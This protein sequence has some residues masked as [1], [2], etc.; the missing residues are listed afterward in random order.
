[1]APKTLVMK[2]KVA[3]GTPVFVGGLLIVG[4]AIITGA[5]FIGKSDSGEIDVTAAIQNS[6]QANIER[7]GDASANVET[8]PETFKNMTNGGL[9]PQENQ[10]EPQAPEVATDA[11]GTTTPEGEATTTATRTEETPENGEQQ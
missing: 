9:V 5:V 6:N 8:I 11:A 2:K 1:M 3:M 4:A 7:G 10:P